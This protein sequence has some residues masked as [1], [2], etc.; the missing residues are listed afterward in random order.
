MRRS[1]TTGLSWGV[2]VNPAP[3]CATRGRF[4]L[5]V[6]VPRMSINPAE[7]STSIVEEDIARTGTLLRNIGTGTLTWS[8]QNPCVQF[9]G[10]NDYATI[11]DNPFF[12][13]IELSDMVTIEAWLRITAFPDAWFSVVDK[14][15][16]SGDF[17]W[18]LQIHQT[19]G[20]NFVATPGAGGGVSFPYVPPLNTWLHLAVAYSSTEGTCR[21]FV[22]G[23]LQDSKPLTADILNTSGE[24]LY[25]GY[26]PSGSNEYSKGQID[27]LRLWSV[28]RSGAE[29]IEDMGRR[30]SGTESGLVA[31]W[32]LDEGAGTT[33]SDRTTHA[34]NGNLLQGSAWASAVDAHPAWIDSRT[35]QEACRLA[36]LSRWQSQS[37]ASRFRPERTGQR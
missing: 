7:I 4:M 25:L 30:L 12:N 28:A 11:S 2:S 15:E 9:D 3:H 22:N 36:R 10:I 19:G 14:Y 18:T 17:G 37:R 20:V 16:S 27:D 33:F 1:A 29:I 35:C 6:E 5:P 34:L 31:C 23:L 32:L 21:L 24:P 13:D 8:L 26:N